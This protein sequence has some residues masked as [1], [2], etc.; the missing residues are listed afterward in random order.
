MA[1]VSIDDFGA[2]MI[3][4]LPGV[5]PTLNNAVMLRQLMRNDFKWEGKNIQFFVHVARNTGIGYVEDGGAIPVADKQDYQEAK[6]YR[7]FL[8]G[9][10]QVTDGTLATASTS[11]KAAE[12]VVTSEL[13]GLI[14]GMATLENFMG[15]QDGTGVVAIVRASASS[16]SSVTIKVSDARMCWDKAVLQVYDSTLATLKGTFTVA[17]VARARDTSGYF[18]VTG[19]LSVNIVSGDRLVWPG[20]LNR[21]PTGL[22]K[23]IDDASTTFQNIST[24]TYPRYTSPVLD[25]G[26][27]G[28]RALTPQLFR[29]M[30]ATVKQEVGQKKDGA[31][32]V[33][34]TNWQ[35]IEVEQLYESELRITPDTKV[36]GVAIAGF[37]SS[38]GRINITT[39]SHA[40][41]NTMFFCDFSQIYRAVQKELDFRRHGQS[42]F[43]PNGSS[44][45]WVADALEI[46][47]YFIKR[48][49]TSGKIEELAESPQTAY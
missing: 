29:Q 26:G 6:A 3:N 4:Y 18:Q 41:F 31:W 22:L 19:N 34:C 15:F 44:Y 9:A 28:N 47:E 33:I 38:F 11:E 40:P 14:E 17:S 36:G 49:N 10:V 27:N 43:R 39:E 12:D 7:R 5:V 46:C 23:L 48:R 20:S 42:I 1:G 24:S 13:R 8:G 45:S 30:M 2:L 32:T 21:A 35:G 25:N 16:S 37:N